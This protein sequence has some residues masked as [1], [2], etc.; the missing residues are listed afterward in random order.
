MNHHPMSDITTVLW[1]DTR[2]FNLK[3]TKYSR[4]VTSNNNILMS[5]L[6]G[7]CFYIE[8]CNFMVYN[9]YIVRIIERQGVFLHWHKHVL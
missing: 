9:L 5:A 1:E 6:I 2:R 4:T 7:G 3:D 8:T